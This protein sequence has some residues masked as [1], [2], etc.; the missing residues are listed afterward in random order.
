MFSSLRAA[1]YQSDTA[2]EKTFKEDKVNA[3]H[4]QDLEF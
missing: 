2:L 3:R 4:T 1:T